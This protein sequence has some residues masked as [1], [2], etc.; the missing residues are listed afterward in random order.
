MMKWFRKH[1]KQVVFLM[2]AMFVIG[3]VIFSGFGGYMA[4]SPYDAALVV[5]GEEIPYKRY[6]RRLEEAMLQ[7]GRDEAPLTPEKTAAL[8]N[9]AVQELVQETVFLQEA[10]RYGIIATD[11]EVA[12]YVQ[13]LPI[14][15]KDGR[16]DQAL[17]FHV[18]GQVLR[19]TPQLF[20]EDRRRELLIHKLQRVMGSAVKMSSAE[21]A[22]ALSAGLSRLPPAE[23][24]SAAADPDAFRKS[25]LQEQ[26]NAVFQA[27]LGQVNS[28]LNVNI[29]LD[30]WEK[31]ETP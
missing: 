2:V 6:Q 14:F 11:N 31:A 12:A 18:L 28:R 8:K 27:W 30:R 4:Q 15:Q 23:R 5:N 26:S 9:R 17:Y 21:T 22:Q 20:E 25:L 3:G 1:K 16:F 13:S 7:R 19:T 24:T 10:A 29:L